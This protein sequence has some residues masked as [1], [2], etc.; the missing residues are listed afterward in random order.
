[1]IYSLLSL[2]AAFSN[3]FLG[4]YVFLKNPRRKTNMCFALLM[5]TLVVWQCG[6]F[7]IR[8]ADIEL[9]RQGVRL[10]ALGVAFLPSVFLYF[11]LIF[12]TEK[13]DY[14]KRKI[15]SLVIFGPPLLFC[16]VVLWNVE[17][18]VADIFPVYWGHAFHEGRL[19]PLFISYFIL[20]VGIA[21]A[22]L[23]N[24]LITAKTAVTRK[25]TMLFF[26]G[27]AIAFLLGSFTDIIAP[28][29]GLYL[30]PL[31]SILTIFS[32]I[33]IAYAV[34]R[35]R[36]MSVYP[37]A[38]KAEKT[39]P[40]YALEKGKT[41]I[42]EERKTEK[43]F[44]IFV[45]LV[46]HG[47]FGLCITRNFPMTIKKK[48]NLE[49]TPFLWLSSIDSSES[50]DPQ[51]LGKMR[52]IIA[53]FVSTSSDSVVLLEGLEYLLVQ[54]GFDRLIKAIHAITEIIVLKDARLLVS[55]NPESFSGWEMSLLKKEMQ[56]IE[57]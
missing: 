56:E 5:A 19:F 42:I 21:E 1:M 29:M 51:D 7:I 39:T 38:E 3:A 11:T 57:D 33:C 50:I 49:K 12:P 2:L 25:Q 37:M 36:L 9:A 30:F 14:T 24:L 6:E 18:L 17:V 55:L 53:E 27:T 45:D 16:V 32:D 23:L 47:S 48:Y 20:Y 40:R 35:Y 4:I 41:Y 28:L 43:A 54:V 31:A 44:N 46:R 10:Y 8:I 52:H 34:L 13:M 15:F 26:G 22:N